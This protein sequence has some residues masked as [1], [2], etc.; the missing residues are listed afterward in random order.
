MDFLNSFTVV[1]F[2]IPS[3][4]VIEFSFLNFKVIFFAKNYKQTLTKNK[5]LTYYYIKLIILRVKLYIVFRVLIIN[6][7]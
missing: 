7:Q 2:L 5:K 3:T 4:F 6:T 1:G